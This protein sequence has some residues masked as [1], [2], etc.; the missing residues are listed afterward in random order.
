[1]HKQRKKKEFEFFLF[2]KNVKYCILDHGQSRNEQVRFCRIFF[3]IGVYTN[4]NTGH[5]QWAWLNASSAHL[6]IEF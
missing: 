6:S 1:M 4:V 2:N 5:E 3:S